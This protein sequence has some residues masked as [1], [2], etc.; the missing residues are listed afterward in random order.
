MSRARDTADQINRVNS[1]A[2]DATAITVDSSENVLIGKTSADGTG[3]TGHDIRATGLAYHTVDGGDVKVLNRLNSD[4]SIL[5][6]RKDNTTVGSIGSKDGDLTIG[7]GDTGLYF[8]DGADS[9]YPYNTSTQADR[10]ASVDIGYPTVRFKDLYLSGGI[11]L[12]GTGSANKLEDYEE[13]SFTPTLHGGFSSGPTSYSR[14]VGVYVKIGKLVSFQIDI[15]AIGASANNSLIQLGGL[16]FT[17][18][19]NATNGYGAAYISYQESFVS[20]NYPQ[21]HVTANSTLIQFYQN[22]SGSA[23]AYNGNA[24]DTNINARLIIVGQY[25]T[26]Q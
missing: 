26:D 10:D 12:G 2:A 23:V 4:G 22:G 21:L 13:G 18:V 25:L 19:Q 8:S 3:S 6:I 7:T 14:Q 24:S 11:H 20:G 9:V 15:K 1:S 17:S 5:S 16:P